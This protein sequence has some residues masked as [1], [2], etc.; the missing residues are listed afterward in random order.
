VTHLRKL[1]LDEIAR[2]NYTE[3]TTRAPARFVSSRISRAISTVH[4]IN[5]DRI[6]FASTPR[7]CFA[8]GSSPTTASIRGSARCD[9]SF[10]KF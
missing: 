3:N 5:S 6:R 2:R 4:P 9:S 8:T 7:T 1:T 10:A